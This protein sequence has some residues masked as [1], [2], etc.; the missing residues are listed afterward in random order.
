MGLFAL[1]R[2]AFEY[3]GVN[4]PLSRIWGDNIIFGIKRHDRPLAYHPV[5]TRRQSETS[6]LAPARSLPFSS[7]RN[8]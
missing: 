2:R 5:R 8:R 4:D 3:N 7:V 6:S 1:L